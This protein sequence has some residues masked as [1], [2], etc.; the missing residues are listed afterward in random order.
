MYSAPVSG[1]VTGAGVSCGS[2]IGLRPLSSGPGGREPVAVSP[3]APP[4]PGIASSSI[5]TGPSR[6]FKN[7]QFVAPA[8]LLRA[9]GQRPTSALSSATR[10]MHGSRSPGQ[11]EGDEGKRITVLIAHGFDEHFESSRAIGSLPKIH[12]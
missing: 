12:M 1:R 6:T 7:A 3:P 10:E 4:S 11:H 5:G 8:G 2:L 9:S